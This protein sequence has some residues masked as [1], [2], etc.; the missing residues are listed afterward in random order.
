MQKKHNEYTDFRLF[1]VEKRNW[2]IIGKWPIIQ[3]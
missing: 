1:L 2:S 3:K